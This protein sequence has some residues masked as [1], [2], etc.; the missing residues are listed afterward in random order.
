MRNFLKAGRIP[1]D[2]LLP[3]W[4]ALLYINELW[5]QLSVRGVHDEVTEVISIYG[6]ESKG[7]KKGV[8]LFETLCGGDAG[9][10]SGTQSEGA[11]HGQKPPFPSVHFSSCI[12]FLSMRVHVRAYSLAPQVRFGCCRHW[13]RH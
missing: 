8:N 2:D 11:R 13:P 10:Q 9:M 6:K 5:R 1:K 3:I 4:P 7:G 12:I